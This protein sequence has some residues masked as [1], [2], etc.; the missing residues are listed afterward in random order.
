MIVGILWVLIGV[1]TLGYYNALL[2]LDDRTPESD[3]NNLKIKKKWHIA[4]SIIFCYLAATAWYIW[5]WKYIPFTLSCFWM[6][7][8]GIVH[9]VALNKSFF[10]VG[11]TAKTDRI[12]RWISPNNPE[13][14]SAIMKSLALIVSTL[15]IF[16]I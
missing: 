11:T 16:L 8:A 12:I 14:V 13:K 1:I 5:G 10:F 3:P 7:F 15:L 4:G 2:I 9:E 6:I